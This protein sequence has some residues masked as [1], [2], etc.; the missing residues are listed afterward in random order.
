M[1]SN[2]RAMNNILTKI[3]FKALPRKP[4]YGT[5]E[6]RGWGGPIPL[7]GSGHTCPAVQAVRRRPLPGGP[8]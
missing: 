1:P 2:R 8:S 6:Q 7:R 4:K 5:W 3:F